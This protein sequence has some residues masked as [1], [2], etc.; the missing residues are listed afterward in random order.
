[1]GDN[2]NL[3]GIAESI[4]DIATKTKLDLT[5]GFKEL[6][7]IVQTILQSYVEAI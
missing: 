2:A 5:D 6:S 4:K 3:L 1:L 7:D